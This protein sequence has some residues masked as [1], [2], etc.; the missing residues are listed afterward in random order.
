MKIANES[1]VL[2]PAIPILS[3]QNKKIV[4]LDIKIF[5][6]WKPNTNNCIMSFIK[7]FFNTIYFKF[8]KIFCTNSLVTHCGRISVWDFLRFCA[9]PTRSF[10]FSKQNSSHRNAYYVSLT[11]HKWRQNKAPIIKT[12]NISSWFNTLR[13]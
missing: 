10:Y 2:T 5:D 12:L 8:I 13:P 1:S 11:F 4:C 3:E 6:T 9:F 7:I